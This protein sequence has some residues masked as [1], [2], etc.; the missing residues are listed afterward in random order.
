MK[1][2]EA[3]YKNDEASK[4][5]GLLETWLKAHGD[6]ATY[7]KLFEAL[8]SS[9]RVDLIDEGLRL[10]EEGELI[11]YKLCSQTFLIVQTRKNKMKEW[12]LIAVI[13]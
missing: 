13:L 10:I 7:L 8:D 2:I 5:V 11:V 9:N 4:K 6:E 3:N 12:I 1:E